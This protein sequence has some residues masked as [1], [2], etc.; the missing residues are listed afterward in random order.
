MPKSSK[1]DDE[2]TIFTNSDDKYL[3]YDDELNPKDLSFHSYG[4]KGVTGAYPKSER[5]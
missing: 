3:A 4:V 1:Q 2:V 5:S